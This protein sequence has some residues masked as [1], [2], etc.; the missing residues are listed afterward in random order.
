MEDSPAT[1][2][3]LQRQASRRSAGIP[4]VD[5]LVGP[6]G[7]ARRASKRFHIHRPIREISGEPWLPLHGFLSQHEQQFLTAALDYLAH[8]GGRDPEQ[9]QRDWANKTEAD[10]NAFWQTLAPESGDD[11]LRKSMQPGERPP[12][13]IRPLVQLKLP[14]FAW[15][16]LFT[17]PTSREDILR[18]GSFALAEPHLTVSLAIS[19]LLWQEF[20]RSAGSSRAE[21]VLF[22]GEFRLP[23][24]PHAEV[25]RALMAGG[26]PEAVARG[27]S[28]VAADAETIAETLRLYHE[29]ATPP[30]TP[31]SDSRAR[32]AAEQYL[33]D[34][35]QDLAETAG[36]FELN[37]TMDFH[38]RT[39]RAEIDMVCRDPKIAI[40]VDG[41]YHFRD[42][43]G[44]RR[45]REKDWVLQKRGFLVLR[46][47]AEDVTRHWD[48][49]RDRIMEA[50]QRSER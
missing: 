32:S 40:E 17:V 4:T 34:R 23:L 44:Y 41:Y 1:E 18:W 48:E 6:V 5:V 36:R 43:D 9:F 20:R 22:E 25:E 2:Q 15:P 29:T 8:R 13:D 14:G 30:A 33:F 16:A 26:V 49:I 3:F 42:D 27:L 50:L 21:A 37:P 10:R 31:E 35:L 39:R 12:E 46:F 19:E 47:L 24:M 28:A 38:F 11:L 7:L 45:D